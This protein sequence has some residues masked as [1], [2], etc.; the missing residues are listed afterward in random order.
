MCPIRPPGGK[1]GGLVTESLPCP[2]CGS[3]RLE[4]FDGD[5]VSC[6][7]CHAYGP[8]GENPVALWNSRAAASP[9]WAGFGRTLFAVWDRSVTWG[10]GWRERFADNIVPYFGDFAL[11]NK[12]PATGVLPDAPAPEYPTGKEALDALRRALLGC[13]PAAAVSVTPAH[14]FDH[15][16]GF[17][18]ERLR[19]A[20][21]RLIGRA[22]DDRSDIPPS[23][24]RTDPN[25]RSGT[26]VQ[27]GPLTLNIPPGYDVHTNGGELY[28]RAE[29]RK[30]GVSVVQWS[31]AQGRTPG[32]SFST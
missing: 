12:I 29:D 13:A 10:K 9:D 2:F 27:C 5:F 3:G 8:R 20:G 7:D 4:N 30:S 21:W 16:A 25:P 14:D 1:K 19:R 31:D 28:V 23:P 11:A 15:W 18:L 6:I 24:A 17:M 32:F 26:T 22:G